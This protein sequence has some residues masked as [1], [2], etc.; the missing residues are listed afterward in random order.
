VVGR[1]HAADLGGSTPPHLLFIS[2]RHKEK[3]Y[4]KTFDA[5]SNVGAGLFSSEP[6]DV[7]VNFPDGTCATFK[8]HAMT[9]QIVV[10]FEKDGVKFDNYKT[11]EE[12][13]E[14]SAKIINR[15]V[16]SGEYDGINI[17]EDLKPRILSNVGLTKTL[18]DA[19]RSLAEEIVEEEEG[20]SES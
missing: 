20:N 3:I 16:V 4:M 15:I 14:N 2:D 5:P 6:I 11:Q 19:S 8:L 9:Q 1:P 7:Q 12:A 18:L 10:E 17:V 13:L